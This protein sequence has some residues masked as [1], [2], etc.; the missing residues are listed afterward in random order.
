MY[1]N[2]GE[3][4]WLETYEMLKTEVEELKATVKHMERYNEAYNNQDVEEESSK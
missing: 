2:T 1:F 4:D 3:V